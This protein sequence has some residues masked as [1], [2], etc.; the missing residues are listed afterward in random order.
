MT[1]AEKKAALRAELLIDPNVL[2]PGPDL[3]PIR[4]FYRALIQQAMNTWNA[5]HVLGPVAVYGD[6]TDRVLSEFFAT[7]ET[8]RRPIDITADELRQPLLRGSWGRIDLVASQVPEYYGLPVAEI[9]TRDEV[10]PPGTSTR[11][12]PSPLAPT[13]TP[14]LDS[15]I[16]NTARAADPDFT[17]HYHGR[18][19]VGTGAGSSVAVWD[20]VAQPTTFVSPTELTSLVRSTL[21]P[22]ARTCSVY[23]NSGGRLSAPLTFTYTNPAPTLDTKVQRTIYCRNL[24]I[25]LQD[26][27]VV[28]YGTR[29]DQISQTLHNLVA[30]TLLT[31]AEVTEILGLMLGGPVTH[32][33]NL[34]LVD[35]HTETCTPADVS[36]A[37]RVP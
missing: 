24:M 21:V 33:F 35:L 4:P 9:A 32:A 16:P 18:D 37:L 13:V 29:Y 30:Q 25:L 15:I 19:F 11:T 14:I 5:G 8:G 20:G 2:C 10:Y 23:I 12:M 34:S 17:M 26:P 7:V 27:A 1:P 6:F 36:V 22:A 28:H 31:E 3:S